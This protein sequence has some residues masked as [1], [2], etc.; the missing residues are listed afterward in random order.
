[1]PAPQYLHTEFGFVSPRRFRRHSFWVAMALLAVAGIGA[2]VMTPPGARVS[3]AAVAPA[4]QMTA[5]TASPAVDQQVANLNGTQV[6]ADKRFCV[7]G[8]L[9]DSDCVSF[10]LP[11]VRMVR[12]PRVASVGQQGNSAKSSVVANSRVTELDKRIAEPRKSQSSAH[13]Q[14]QR[15]NQLA[16]GYASSGSARQG[17][18]RNF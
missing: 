3:D 9:S 7:A 2:A 11:K 16:R 18:A 15:R 6:V 5:A 10:Q 12:V 8:R 1:V 14:S 4:G 13:R 17:F